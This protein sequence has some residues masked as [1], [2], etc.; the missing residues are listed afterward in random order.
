MG[1]IKPDL[2][3]LGQSPRQ[4]CLQGERLLTL[5]AAFTSIDCKF[6][7]GA[8]EALGLFHTDASPS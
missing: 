8:A 2:R 1:T 4:I 5:T 3:E 7:V 6:H